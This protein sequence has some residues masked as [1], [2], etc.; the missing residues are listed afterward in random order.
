MTARDSGAI[1]TLSSVHRTW[2]QSSLRQTSRYRRRAVQI[3]Y[4]ISDG[5]EKLEIL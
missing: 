2:E 5:R 3:G 4:E 1:Q